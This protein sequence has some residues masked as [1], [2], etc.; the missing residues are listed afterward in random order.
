[1]KTSIIGRFEEQKRL[2]EIRDSDR[3]E[4][5]AIYG[6]RR[7]GKTFLI[8][9]IFQK[10]FAFDLAGLAKSNT[11]NQLINFNQSLNRSFNASYHVPKHWF[12]AFD[13]LITALSRLNRTRKI[14]FIDEISWLDAP[15][16]DF[17]PA[18]EHFWNGWACMRNDIVLIVCGSATSWIVNNIMNNHGGLHNRLTANIHL[19]AFT[20]RECEQ[21]FQS[22]NIDLSRRQIA[23]TYMVMGGIPYY[24]SLMQKGM[25]VNQNVDKIFFDDNA[26]LKNEFENLYAS[27]FKHSDEYIAVVKALSLKNKGLS[28]KEILEY[29]KKKSGNKITAILK[30]LEYCGFI[31]SYFSFNKKERGK[32]FQLIDSFTLFYFNFIEK[33]N[34]Q[35]NHFWTNSVNLPQ[36]NTWAGYAFE[37]L[38]LQHI[39]GIKKSLGISGIRTNTCSWK[40]ENSE[41][42]CQIDLLIDRIDG[43][44]NMV[45]IKFCNE[46]YCISKDY[47]NN[48]QNKIAVF[49][50]ESKTK[51]AIHLVMLTT[52]GILQNKYSGIVQ[53]EIRLD[54][55]FA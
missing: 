30:D 9:Q 28:R 45:E 26:L 21:Y 3:P 4:F 38:S 36:Y 46:I 39:A 15:K 25:S 48:L 41:P 43:I 2:L 11:V 1:M 54:D 34:F 52:F 37:I 8:R 22:V 19:R 16:S 13:Q 47:E 40:S 24:L 32:I 44:I 12:E 7:V 55:L 31:R 33:Y 5:V 50:F 35:D 14:V 42:G 10:S 6:R 23:E 51:K 49:R 20:L 17:L 29:L 27:L 18:L 53:K